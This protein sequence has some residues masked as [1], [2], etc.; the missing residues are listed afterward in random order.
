M[1]KAQ[2]EISEKNEVQIEDVEEHKGSAND[3]IIRDENGLSMKQG[4]LS[5]D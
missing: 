5:M 3:L 1:M 4:S 2:Q